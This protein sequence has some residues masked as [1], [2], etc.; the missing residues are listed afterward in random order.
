MYYSVFS[1][2][3]LPTVAPF[4]ASRIAAVSPGRNFCLDWV[5]RNVYFKN[6]FLMFTSKDVSTAKAKTMFNYSPH[7]NLLV[8]RKYSVNVCEELFFN[9]YVQGT[10]ILL[11]SYRYYSSSQLPWIRMLSPPLRK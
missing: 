9:V 11:L 5:V 8:H 2:K 1:K 7:T 3:Y 6:I 4:E 10:Q